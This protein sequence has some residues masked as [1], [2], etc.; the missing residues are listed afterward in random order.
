MGAIDFRLGR[1]FSNYTKE[2]LPPGRL[3]PLPVSII[4]CMDS[5]AQG[6]SPRGKAIEDLA[7]IAFFFLLQP[8]EYC[9]GGTD[10]VSTPFTLRNIQFFVVTQHTQSTKYSPTLCAAATFVI[11]LFKT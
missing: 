11:L 4:H 7:W 6:G 1:Q 10:T 3:L 8:L 5:V 9:S 2:Y